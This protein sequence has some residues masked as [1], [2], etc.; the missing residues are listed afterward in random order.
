MLAELKESQEQALFFQWFDMQYKNLSRLAFAV[1]NGAWLA[2]DKKTRAILMNSLKKQGLRKGVSDI[3]ILKP[4]GK[5]HGL[6][7]E[8]KRTSGTRSKITSDQDQFL[9][10]ASKEGYF[11]C[12]CFG[13]TALKIA[14]SNYLEGLSVNDKK[15][16]IY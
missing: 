4:V 3:I 12:A 9:E 13:F 1:P 5:Y 15:V 7:L 10:A 14:T 6:I 2:G 11:S 16:L 8:T